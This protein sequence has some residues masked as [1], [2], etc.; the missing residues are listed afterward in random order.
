MYVHRYITHTHVMHRVAVVDGIMQ[1]IV[2]VRRRRHYTIFVLLLLLLYIFETAFFIIRIL[3]NLI[4]YFILY[5]IWLM[6]ER[7]MGVMRTC[8]QTFPRPLSL[9]YT[10]TKY[11]VCV[12]P[13]PTSSCIIQYRRNT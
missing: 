7:H 5:F 4:F 3:F 9:L 8:Q 11:C 13:I 2:G 12:T 1:M 6:W 10:R